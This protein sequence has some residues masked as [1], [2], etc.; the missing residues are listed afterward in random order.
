MSKDDALDFLRHMSSD[1]ETGQKVVAEYKR[2]LQ[3]LAHEKGFE[4]TEAEL[5]EAAEALKD[6]AAGEISDVAVAMVVGGSWGPNDD[7]AQRAGK[8]MDPPPQS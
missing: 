3:D 8:F 6:A 2:L 7:E 4:F 5:M 1:P